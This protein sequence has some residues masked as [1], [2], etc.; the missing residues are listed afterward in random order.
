[1]NSAF[2]KAV[3]INQVGSVDTILRRFSPQVGMNEGA[4]ESIN[5]TVKS[6]SQMPVLGETDDIIIDLTDS[7]NIDVCEFN[8]SYFE[9]Y[10]DFTLDLFQGKFPLLPTDVHPDELVGSVETWTNWSTNPVLQDIAKTTF[11]FVG[12]K[13]ATDCIRYYRIVHNGR[14]VGPT[15]KDKV[16]IESYLF[17][18]MKPRT[19]KEN[20]A[21]TFS[22]W[23]NVHKHN[24]SICGQYISLW[25]LYQAQLTGTNSIHINFPV[26]IGFDDLLPFQNFGDFPSRVLGDFRLIIHVSPD[27]LVWCSVDPAA[28]ITQ[29]AETYPFTQGSIGEIFDYKKFANVI[30]S[31]NQ[32]DNYDHR[33]TQVNTFGRA[34]SNC[35]SDST[36]RSTPP[37]RAGYHGVDILL[38]PRTISTYLAQSV[39]SG[40]KL[41]NAYITHLYNLYQNEP[42]VVPAEMIYSDNMGANPSTSGIEATKQFK[43][44]HVKEVCVLFPRYVSDY[45]VQFNPCLEKLSITM[46]NHDYPDKET[47]TTSARFLR[48]QLE[49]MGLDTILECTE[50]LEQSYTSPPSYL[51]P[52]RDRSLSDNTDFVFVIPVERSSA[53][54]FFFDGLDSGADTE[55]LTISGKFITDKDNHKIDTYAILNRNDKIAITNDSY[56]R[57]PPLVCLITDTF[58]LF[59][60]AN[61]LFATLDINEWQPSIPHTVIL[62]DDAINVLKD[63]KYKEVRDLLFQNR[64]PRLTVFICVQDIFGVP[65]QLR[66][67]CDTVFIF[68]GMTD[69]MAFGMMLN[70]LGISGMISWDQYKMIPYRG[71]LVVDYLPRGT[72][73]KI[74]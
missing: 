3:A 9:L 39:L 13:N 61:D 16:Q 25:D 7:K 51:T 26:I 70:Q 49:A 23:E 4:H 17:N 66:R 45:T 35:V 74:A 47:D 68:A 69:K 1:M 34:A 65:V 41:D 29:L 20:K 22:L 30:S 15:I 37:T 72:I 33:F 40:Y 21:N 42:F 11:F 8:R 38:K 67:N 5:K 2:Q 36:D 14:D 19:D 62:L 50:S 43:F 18:V 58:W 63:N 52:T 54:A 6:V 60:S 73:L 32:Q 31:I 12:F 64:Q 10:L 59:T 28:S 53:N 55:T 46:F 57:T 56:N 24:N 71:V 44:T 27:A 48:S